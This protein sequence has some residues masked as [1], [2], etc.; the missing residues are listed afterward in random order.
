M[1]CG[2]HGRRE[3]VSRQLPALLLSTVMILAIVVSPCATSSD[4]IF[5]SIPTSDH[6]L[7]PRQP[8]GRDVVAHTAVGAEAKCHHY[9]RRERGR[10]RSRAVAATTQNEK[11][12]NEPSGTRTQDPLLKRRSSLIPPASTDVVY[13]VSIWRFLCWPVRERLL[14][15]APCPP[16]ATVWLQS[17]ASADTQSASRSCN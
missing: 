3:V 10:D 6:I 14:R 15:H 1:S 11:E 2:H 4:P 9:P 16:V 12:S 17:P 13:R 5:P 8:A 7:C